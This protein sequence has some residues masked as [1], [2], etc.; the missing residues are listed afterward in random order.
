[1]ALS[2]EAGGWKYQK[3]QRLRAF[4]ATKILVVVEDMESV[5]FLLD[6]VTKEDR[7]F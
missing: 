4:A 5:G 3:S 7:L 2:T 1:M 6:F